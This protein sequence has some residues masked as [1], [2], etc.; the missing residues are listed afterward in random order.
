MIE[1]LVAK[2]G[3]LGK[4]KEPLQL[5][6]GLGEDKEQDNDDEEEELEEEEADKGK[7]L[8]VVMPQS[9]KDQRSKVKKE[10]TPPPPTQPRTRVAVI[11]KKFVKLKVAKATESSE[12]Q[13]RRRRLVRG[14]PIIQ[15][16]TIEEVCDKIRSICLTSFKHVKYD[17]LDNNDK[18]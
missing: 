1:D 5:T 12:P 13:T 17:T 6:Q 3:T 8:V 18:N 11:I 10:T 9:K 14:Q 4:G 2:L 7:A 15:I 16:K